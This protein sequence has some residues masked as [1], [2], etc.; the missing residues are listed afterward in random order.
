MRARLRSG[1]RAFIHPGHDERSR[2]DNKECVPCAVKT[3]V[4]TAHG[5]QT[6]QEAGSQSAASSS[7]GTTRTVSQTTR[8]SSVSSG[9]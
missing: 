1:V 4:L 2:S 9:V 8:V 3:R 6:L 5:T 7:A